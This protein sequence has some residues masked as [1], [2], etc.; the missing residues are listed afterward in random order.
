MVLYEVERR[1]WDSMITFKKLGTASDVGNFYKSL[2]D[3]GV[4]FYDTE[5]S[6]YEPKAF[7]TWSLT[8]LSFNS[9]M[10]NQIY[11]DDNVYDWELGAEEELYP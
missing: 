7:D 9:D 11:A 10:Q 8:K 5:L 1:G 4:S 3:A 6:T 2:C